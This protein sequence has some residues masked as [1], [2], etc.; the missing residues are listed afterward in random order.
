M[1]FFRVTFGIVSEHVLC[2][3]ATCRASRVPHA[4]VECAT[5]IFT[6]GL[7][8][9]PAMCKMADNEHLVSTE[10]ALLVAMPLK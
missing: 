10:S 2:S 1:L 4:G 9:H 3:V 6:A 5:M 7:Y 8:N